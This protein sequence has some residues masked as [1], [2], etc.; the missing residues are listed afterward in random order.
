M[1]DNDDK[2]KKALL[3]GVSHFAQSGFLSGLNNLMVFPMYHETFSDKFGFT[4]DD[5]CVFFTIMDRMT[6]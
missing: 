5:I 4:K 1:Q 2:I 3:V 6:R